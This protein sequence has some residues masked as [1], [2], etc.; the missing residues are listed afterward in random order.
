MI[1]I[2]ISATIISKYPCTWFRGLIL[3]EAT[4]LRVSLFLWIL[5]T[6]KQNLACLKRRPNKTPSPHP[7]LL[8]EACHLTQNKDQV[9]IFPGVEQFLSH[10]THP[11]PPR[12]LR[13]PPQKLN[14]STGIWTTP[15]STHTVYMTV[16]NLRTSQSLPCSPL[17][18]LTIN[19]GK[20]ER[21]YSPVT[22]VLDGQAPNN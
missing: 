6:N 14:P 18:R 16:G 12:V 3:L 19:A 22:G 7:S 4:Q 17:S 10:W 8:Q 1:P 21:G 20:G 11:R 15:M 5:Q 9:W 13:Q 2:C